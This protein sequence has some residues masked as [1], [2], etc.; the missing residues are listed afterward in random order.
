MSISGALSNAMTGLRAAGR[1]S[2]VISA[3]L[4]NAMTPG[5][6]VRNLSL[7]SSQLGG[8]AID[9]VMRNVDPSLLADLRLAD[10]S[11]GNANNRTKFLNDF[12]NLLGTPEEANSLAGRMA[13]FERTLITAASRPDAPERLNSV[14]DAARDI[15]TLISKAS[16]GV[17][18]ARSDADRA[19]QVQIDR[20]NTSLQSVKEL[21]SQITRTISTGSDASALFDNRQAIVDEI[22]AIVPVRLVPRDN[23]QIALYSTGGAIL[24]DGGVA[25]IEFNAVNQV[26][27]FMTLGGG[28]LSG[29]SVNGY[30][31]RTDS[32]RGAL[33]GGTLG[34][35]FEIRD[36]LGTSAQ[37]QLDAFARDLIERFQD[38]AVDASL[39][40]GDPGIFTDAGLA[41]DPVN[42]IGLSARLSVNAAVDERQGGESWRIRDGVNALTPGDVGDARLIQALSDTLSAKRAPASGDFGAGAFSAMNLISTFTSQV[43]ADRSRAEQTLSFASS[44]FDELTQQVLANGVDSDQE[45]QR[46]LIVEQAY[47]ANARMI[48]AADEMM[49]TILRI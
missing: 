20:L 17:Q 30:P 49:Q 15:A 12:E 48:E 10:A 43:G 36:E 31:V 13:E 5:Y 3:N 39:A 25:E 19:I 29:L 21:N 22:N 4:A 45:L 37:T 14:V 11:F 9:G 16:D 40:V 8:V 7:S 27:P 47:A 42:E 2:E 24:I 35:H 18:Q 26:T 46:L 44:Q 34:A 1:T 33:G 41:F 6:G 32:A 23:G 38:P 28:T